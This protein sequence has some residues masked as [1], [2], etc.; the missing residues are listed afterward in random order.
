MSPGWAE[1]APLAPPEDSLGQA[2]RSGLGFYQ[3]ISF[4]LYAC[5]HETLYVPVKN[6]V[7]ISHGPVGL[8][9]LSPT[10]LQSQ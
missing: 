5:G 1:G 10:D 3:I 4:T 7:S 8:L 6:E 2:G 9:E